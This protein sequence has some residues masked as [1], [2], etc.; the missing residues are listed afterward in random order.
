[1]NC[2]SPEE[3]VEEFWRMMQAPSNNEPR[4]SRLREILMWL[5]IYILLA[6]WIKTFWL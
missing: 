1:M 2:K 3:E 4:S 5:I 6:M